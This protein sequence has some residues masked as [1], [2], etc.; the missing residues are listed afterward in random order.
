MYIKVMNAVRKIAPANFKFTVL[1]NEKYNFIVLEIKNMDVAE[2]EKLKFV[3]FKRFAKKKGFV[4]NTDLDCFKDYDFIKLLKKVLSTAYY[5]SSDGKHN[6][7]L[8]TDKYSC[9]VEF[10]EE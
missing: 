6:P 8:L 1:V 3:D 4:K 10:A 5:A 7:F 9:Y 2:H